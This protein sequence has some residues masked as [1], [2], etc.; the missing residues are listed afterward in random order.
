MIDALRYLVLAVETRHAHLR[1]QRLETV[2]VVEL[3]HCI[4]IQFF[5]DEKLLLVP[6]RSVPAI[7]KILPEFRLQR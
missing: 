6:N 4:E 7:R 3:L 1:M 5:H 2:K